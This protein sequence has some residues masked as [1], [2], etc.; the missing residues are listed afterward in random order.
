MVGIVVTAVVMATVV[1][2]LVWAGAVIDMVV[3][4][5]LVFGVRGVIVAV[6]VILDDVE[7]ILAEV[8]VG[9]CID[10]SAD[11][12][13]GIVFGIGVEVSTGVCVNVCAAVATALL[14]F[15]IATTL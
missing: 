5:V 1:K 2:V 13:I 11:V 8:V 9:V 15:P 14:E 12:I 4:G 7:I 10:V 3:G 6:I